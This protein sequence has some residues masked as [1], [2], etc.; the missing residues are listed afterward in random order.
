MWQYDARKPRQRD[1]AAEVE[2]IGAVKLLIQQPVVTSPL[3]LRPE[4]CVLP[5]LM[6]EAQLPLIFFTTRSTSQNP[7][8]Q[9]KMQHIL[10]HHKAPYQ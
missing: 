2:G 5:T 7:I 9:V 4:D 3:E 8:P 1:G 6:F 10:S